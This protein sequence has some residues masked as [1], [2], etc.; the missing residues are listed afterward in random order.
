MRLR[1]AIAGVVVCM[2]VRALAQ[3]QPQAPLAQ[4]PTLSAQ[5]TLVLVPALVRNKAGQLL[6][7]LKASD[8]ALTDDGVPQKLRLEQDTDR[9]PLALVVDIEGGGQAARELE[10]GKFSGIASMLDA[11]VG[12]VPHRIAVVGFDS[13]PALVTDFTPDTEAAARGIRALI[14]D[15]SGDG[16][17]AILDSLGF[18]LDLLRKQPPEYRRA[19]LLISETNGSKSKLKM[20]D[21][22]RAVSD[23]NTIIYAAA[24]STGKSDAGEIWSGIKSAPPT[25]QLSF[26]PEIEMA[27]M[28]AIVAIDGLR[29]NIP[30]TVARV[31]GGE[32]FQFISEKGL[33]RDLDMI[34]NH[35]PNRYMLSFQPPAPHPGY[36]GLRLNV[37]NYVGLEVSAR[38]GYWANP[39]QPAAQ[40]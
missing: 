25:G 36:H 39:V 13:S 33:A 15:D 29:K 11:I 10:I 18:S 6:Y 27:R 16:G 7:T 37:P 12:G 28:A 2:A 32:Y 1:L 24:F 38:N 23:T 21:A 40:P 26:M 31:T 22:L 17:A 4:A 35:I 20:E 14:A 5:S 3:S 8:F 19:I 34:G 30:E 9:E